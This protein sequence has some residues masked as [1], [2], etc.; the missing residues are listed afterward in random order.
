MQ[1]TMTRRLSRNRKPHEKVSHVPRR[2]PRTYQDPC[3][4]GWYVVNSCRRVAPQPIPTSGSLGR[5]PLN[6]GCPSRKW[7]GKTIAAPKHGF[8]SAKDHGYWV[9]KVKAQKKYN[10]PRKVIGGGKSYKDVLTTPATI[11]IKPTPESILLA[12]KIQNSTFKSRG[13][14]TL[15]QEKIPLINRFQELLIEKEHMEEVEEFQPFVTNDSRAQHLFCKKV[16]RKVGRRETLVCPITNEE[17]HLNL[18]AGIRARVVDSMGSIVHEENM[19]EYNRGHVVKSMRKRIVHERESKPIPVIGSFSDRAIRVLCDDHTDELASA[20][21]VPSEWKPSKNQRAVPY[22]PQNESATV[23]STRPD[24]YAPV[25]VCTHKQYMKVQRVFLDAMNIMRALRFHIDAKTLRETWVKCWLQ[26]HK[27]NV[28]FPG[29]MIA[30][31]LSGTVPC[32]QEFLLPCVN[33][34]RAFATVCYA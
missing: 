29:W 5:K 6:P 32:E 28:A 21:S 9:P 16:L 17:S 10:P 20:S 14:V 1:K 7:T 12:Q 31:L 25:K 27:K 19:P 2:G 23:V 8:Y 3:D 13:K 24:W 4:P 15:S 26:V 22:L 33:E 30:P 18:K 34:T 11:Q